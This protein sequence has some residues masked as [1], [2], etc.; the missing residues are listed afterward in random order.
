M[1]TFFTDICSAIITKING[2]G[3]LNTV[4]NYEI[5]KPTDGKYP[6]ATVTPTRFDGEFGDTIRNI[7]KYEFAIRV[8]QERVE[9]G[10]GNEKT[11]RVIRT[12]ADEILTAFDADT[13]LSGMVKMIKPLSGSFDYVDREIG[14]TRICEFIVEATA[15]VPSIT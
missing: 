14:D 1:S 6:F 8:Y 15:V 4:Y 7:R 10:F 5:D 9:A 12:I 2:V 13:T 3:T 11:E